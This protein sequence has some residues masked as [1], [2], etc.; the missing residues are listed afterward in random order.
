MDALQIEQ[1][2]KERVDQHIL[3]GIKSFARWSNWAGDLG[4]ECDTYQALCRL[5]PELKPLPD[6]GLAKVFRASGMLEAPNLR[7]LEEAGIKIVEQARPYTWNEKKISGRIDA[8]IEFEV[9]G[10]L[11]RIPLE[12]KAL[13]P[14]SYRTVLKHKQDGISLRQSKYSWMRKYPGQLQIYDL[15]DGSEYGLWMF[16][17]KVCG[18][19][20][21]WLDPIDYT[22][23]E[24]LIQRAER[25]N[26]AVEAGTI[27]E[28]ERKPIC[29]GCDFER[30]HCFV[31]K[32]GG[33]GWEFITDAE[34]LIKVQRY[35]EIKPLTSEAEDLWDEF[36]AAFQAKTVIIG[37]QKFESKPFHKN[38]FTVQPSDGF[39]LSMRPL[40]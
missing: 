23:T 24:E 17:E 39:R 3:S 20:F 10:K 40:K 2:L 13:S 34:W 28:P 9:D 4:F 18:D 31:G 32:E 37:D 16:Y 30:T 1:N 11:L 5:K 6:L 25:T 8:K 33:E 14:N 29:E 35:L 7:L 36:K 21:F 15:M 38:G 22:Y 26:A 19:Y 27:P 12:H